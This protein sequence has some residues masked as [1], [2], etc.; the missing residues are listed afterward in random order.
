MTRNA[1]LSAKQTHINK[2]L[3]NMASMT[4]HPF[5]QHD[6]IPLGLSNFIVFILQ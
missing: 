6:C 4:K 1:T 3:Y 2:I 5:L